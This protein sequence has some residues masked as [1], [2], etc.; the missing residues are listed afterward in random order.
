MYAIKGLGARTE[1]RGK[2]RFAERVYIVEGVNNHG[3]SG[4]LRQVLGHATTVVPHRLELNRPTITHQRDEPALTAWR[5][6]IDQRYIEGNRLEM[7]GISLERSAAHCAQGQK[8]ASQRR[9]NMFAFHRRF[10]PNGNSPAS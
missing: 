8:G 9:K 3:I 10:P 6:A 2:E 4:Y 7:I 5:C 1:A